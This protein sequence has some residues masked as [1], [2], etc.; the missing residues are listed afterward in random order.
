MKEVADREKERAQERKAIAQ[1][2]A[3]ELQRKKIRAKELFDNLIT[4]V[5]V[6]REV[7]AVVQHFSEEV[8]VSRGADRLK[9]I[10]VETAKNLW[11]YQI[12]ADDFGLPNPTIPVD[13]DAMLDAFLT[14]LGK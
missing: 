13:E 10:P 8:L 7:D 9:I 3:E 5:G 11:H 6:H 4:Y 2:V 14:F 12:D 1:A